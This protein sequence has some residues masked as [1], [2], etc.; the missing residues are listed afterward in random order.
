MSAAHELDDH[1]AQAAPTPE[2]AYVSLPA[3]LPASVRTRVTHRRTKPFSYGFTHHTTAWVVDAA[4]PEAA[5]PRWLRPL[6][7]IRSRD[8][9][10]DGDAS[11]QE[12]VRRFVAAEGLGWATDR[13][14]GLCA[15]RSLGHVFDPLSVWFCFDADGEPTGVLAEVHNTYG[16]RHTYPLPIQRGRA[17]VD[18]DFY[19]SPFFTVEGRYD[20]RVRLD[21]DRVAVAIS[22]SQDGEVVFTGSEAGALRPVRSRLD[23]LRAVL[24][25]PAPALRVAALIRWHGITLWIK[26]LPVVRRRPHATQEGMT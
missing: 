19:V 6:A 22:L 20:I 14:V 4:D 10:G 16:E 26:R 13:V 1:A 25:D 12:K 21:S 17:A 24:R 2:R 3:S 5:F 8:H 18:K 23:T 15:A 11:L 9:F 7:R